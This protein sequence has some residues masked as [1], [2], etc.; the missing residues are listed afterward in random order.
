MLLSM[1]GYGAASRSSH[2][3]K[4]T[5]ELRSL[6]SKFFELSTRLPK[7]Y[8]KF[9]NDIRQILIQKLNRGKVS[10]LLNVEVLQADKRTL[11]IN[12]PLAAR[13]L[14]ELRAFADEL[15]IPADISLPFVL[16]LPE[17]IP[18]E[19]D[20]EDPEEWELVQLALGAA[21]DHMLVS[22]EEEGKALD[23]DLM[24]RNDA[25]RFALTEIEK[26]APERATAVRSRLDQA[27]ADL[28]DKVQDVDP[29][30]FEQELIYYLE[31][32]DINEEIV[33]LSQ[34]IK[35]FNELREN[36]TSNGKQLQFVSQEM[37][38]EINTIGSKA[39]HAAI[40]R[41]V[42]AMKDDLERIKEQVLNIM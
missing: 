10:L 30:R 33:R 19:I 37:G 9:E 34:H 29:N 41:L 39:N 28:R 14:E 6:N 38:R 2:N 13:Y 12:K 32:L 42:V 36:G 8:A 1:T 20:Q 18:T 3:Y 11:N 16:E 15:N 5:I 25:I 31:K 23:R 7:S 24:E 26:L 22:R 35:F 17:V 40:Q 21:I 27:L 4:V